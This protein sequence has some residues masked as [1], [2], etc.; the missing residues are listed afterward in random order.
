MK[1]PKGFFTYFH[2]DAVLETLSDEQAGRLYKALLRYGSTGE[3][4]DYKSDS[5]LNV[6]FT[7]FRTE[8][9]YNFERYREISE[10]RS[11]AAKEREA[12]KREKTKSRDQSTNS[13]I[14][15]KQHNS[16]HTAQNALYKDKDNQKDNE[17]EM[18]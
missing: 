3:L 15:H 18:K 12:K 16:A 14:P 6:A 17:N 2:H 5:G 4:P 7:L 1:T 9:D 8:I 10:A 11:E 13:T